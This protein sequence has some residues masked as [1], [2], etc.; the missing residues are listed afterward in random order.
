[1][2]NESRTRNIDEG[3][4]GIVVQHTIGVDLSN[5]MED[6]FVKGRIIQDWF[7]ERHCDWYPSVAV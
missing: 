5:F 6:A 3:C 7:E 4:H 2:T 1:M